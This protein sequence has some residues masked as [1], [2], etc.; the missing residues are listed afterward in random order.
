MR[1][2]TYPLVVE[3]EDKGGAETTEPGA[4]VCEGITPV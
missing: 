1:Q 3:E 4:W 2:D